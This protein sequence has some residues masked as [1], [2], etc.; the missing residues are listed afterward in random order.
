MAPSIVIASPITPSRVIEAISVVFLARFLGTYMAYARSPLGALALKR[1]M[2]VWKPALL[3]DKPEPPGVEAGS[4]PA[5]QPS[6]LLVALGGYWDFFERPA[7]PFGKTGDRPAH[8]GLRDLHPESLLECLAQCSSRV[9][10]ELAR[11]W[12]GNHSLS[13]LPLMAGG[14][15]GDSAP[16]RPVSLSLRLFSQSV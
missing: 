10:S 9:R 16:T 8:R 1:V 12:P 11:R 3:D 2:E 15:G 5:P 6:D 13:I 7:V 14:V 4:K